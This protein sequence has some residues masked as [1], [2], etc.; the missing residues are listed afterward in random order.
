MV[1]EYTFIMKNDVWAVVPRLEE[2]SMVTSRWL[3]K[4]KHATNVKFKTKSV[5]RGF[6]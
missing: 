4:T 3:F 5:A 2:K 6:S 1:E